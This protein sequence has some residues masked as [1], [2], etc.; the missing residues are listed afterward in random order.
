[1]RR[2]PRPCDRH[3]SFFSSSSSGGSSGNG[4]RAHASA[5]SWSDP[6]LRV[7][8]IGIDLP[9]EWEAIADDGGTVYYMHKSSLS[10]QREHPVTGKT[11]TFASCMRGKRLPVR[12]PRCRRLT[13]CPRA[14]SARP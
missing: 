5:R 6:R 11:V 9:A 13:V 8:G 4:R 2:V 3:R 7:I 1:M 14:A 10:M 12:R